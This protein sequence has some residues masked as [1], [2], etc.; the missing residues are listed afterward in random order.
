MTNRHLI[1]ATSGLYILGSALFA[2]SLK[3][4]P[5]FAVLAGCICAI[6]L[7]AGR[8]PGEPAG[9]I[10]QRIDLRFYMSCLAAGLAILIAGGEGHFVFAVNDWLIRDAVLADVARTGVNTVYDYQGHDYLLRAPLG[11][12]LIPGALGQFTS[13]N[14]A[15]LVMLA[16]NAVLLASVFYVFGLLAPRA[17][18]M[19]VALFILFG[20]LDILPALLQGYWIH[21]SVGQF[22]LPAR[23][24]AWAPWF[25]YWSNISSLFW[26]P[27]HTL[28]AWWFAAL[29]LLTARR[30][31]GMHVLVASAPALAL[32]TPF[33]IMIAPVLGLALLLQAPVRALQAPRNWLAAGVVCLFA[34]I[35][36]YLTVASATIPSEWTVQR[37]GFWA[38]YAL[39]LLIQMPQ[40]IF[41]AA[42]WRTI[43]RDDRPLL[44][45]A[46]VVLLVVPVYNFGGGFDLVARASN[47][48]LAILAFE[49]SAIFVS[50]DRS[51]HQEGWILAVSIVALAI[52]S[53][54]IQFARAFM[55]PRFAISD[56]SL[57][58]A[59]MDAG[60]EG[61]PL[62]YIAAVESIPA[63]LIAPALERRIA[64]QQ[65]NCWPDHPMPESYHR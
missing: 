11:M 45:A 20:G 60:G 59:T 61:L 65:R 62:H 48:A 9:I 58:S 38:V 35:G 42:Y 37:D 19:V 30:K 63:W 22:I 13:L 8:Q 34:P 41:V 46:I 28:P 26:V 7:M 64:Y 43:D 51:K 4:W 29:A 6:G 17:R 12:Y 14:S 44:S 33:V 54:G 50:F 36:V 32:W 2:L 31:I 25:S 57:L 55:H 27:N 1:L 24:S 39:T 16:Q 40:L 10:E 47:A 56:C 53:P 23:L 3:P 15:H 49:F 18:M 5:M 21:N 52:L